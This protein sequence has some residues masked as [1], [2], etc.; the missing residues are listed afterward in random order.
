ME[1]I[2]TK[3]AIS[4]LEEISAAKEI[5]RVK[6]VKLLGYYNYTVVLT[7]IGM[8]IGFAGS[9]CAINGKFQESLLCLIIAGFCDMFDGKLA[10]TKER[11]MDEKRF[12]IQI[13]SLSDLVS[14]GLFPA[15]FVYCFAADNY[16]GMFAGGIFVLCAL[17]RLAYFNVTEE[18]RQESSGTGRKWYEG[19]PVTSI[20]LILPLLYILCSAGK[21]NAGI[22]FPVALI[23][24]SAAFLLPIKIKKPE[25]VGKIVIISAGTAEFIKIIWDLF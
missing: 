2:F 13:D 22:V 3:E 25:L 19:L 8:L 16:Q 11:S 24:V 15:V 23:A 12:G 7:Y 6:E 4:D 18:Q 1:K 14:F 5:F 9:I 17:I 10:S 20:A 21:L